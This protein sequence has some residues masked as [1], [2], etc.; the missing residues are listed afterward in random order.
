MEKLVVKS[1]VSKKNMIIMTL[2]VTALTALVISSLYKWFVL[3]L[4]QPVELMAESLVL[5]V[6]IERMSAKYTYEMDKKVLRL[7]KHGLLGR[8][9]H[10]VPYRDIFGVYRYKPQLIGVI[11]FRRTYRFN[12]ALDSRE[13]W[14]LAYTVPG[15]KGKMEN[16]RFY[17][18]PGPQLLAALRAKLPEKVVVEEKIIKDVVLA[19]ENIEKNKKMV[20]G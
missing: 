8:I 14:T 11:K 9:T 2:A 1:E 16:R 12:S 18:K 5:F 7:V 15:R 17:I 19:E 20:K 4:F 6:L 3:S 10:E 13:L